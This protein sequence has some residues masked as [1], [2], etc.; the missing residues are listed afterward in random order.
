LKKRF[1]SAKFLADRPLL[2]GKIAFHI[3]Y[4]IASA[5][6]S[7]PS[8]GLGKVTGRT[9]VRIEIVASTWVDGSLCRAPAMVWDALT[10]FVNLKNLNKCFSALG[11]NA[12]AG[13]WGLMCYVQCALKRLP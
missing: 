7:E 6:H 4:S 12:S 13:V 5:W 3:F 9:R 11:L 2:Y 10:K 8:A 1:S